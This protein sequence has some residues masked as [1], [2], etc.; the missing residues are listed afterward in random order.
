M[1]KPSRRSSAYRTEQNRLAQRRYRARQ[2]AKLDALQGTAAT[3][4]SLSARNIPLARPSSTEAADASSHSARHV[5]VHPKSPPLPASASL[6]GTR[7]VSSLQS[8]S[9]SA[10]A[11]TSL[12]TPLSEPAQFDDPSLM[13]LSPVPWDLASAFDFSHQ[14]DV[15]DLSFTTSF[16]AYHATNNSPADGQAAETTAEVVGLSRQTPSNAL[17]RSSTEIDHIITALQQHRPYTP[18]PRRNHFRMVSVNIVAATLANASQLCPAPH[19]RKAHN[20]SPFFKPAAQA[21]PHLALTGMNFFSFLS[22]DMRPVQKQI[23]VPHPVWIDT[24]PI[25]TFR[26]AVLSNWSVFGSDSHSQ[27]LKQLNQDILNGAFVCWGSQRSKD[28]IGA[29]WDARSWE[30]RSCFFSKWGWLFEGVPGSEELVRSSKW[31]ATIRGE[32]QDSSPDRDSR[33]C[34][35]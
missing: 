27:L 26:E 32:E 23:S 1:R 2:K 17:P 4:Q 28:G 31:W 24:I 20:A 30:V 22:P 12:P 34:E 16:E 29:P 5:Y 10:A 14:S 19:P 25:P 7:D 15:D 18:C 6:H 9:S 3:E 13:G 8:S 33:I 35:Q 21:Q 11:S